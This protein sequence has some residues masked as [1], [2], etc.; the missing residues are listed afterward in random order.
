[1]NILEWL[2]GE[3]QNINYKPKN[4]MVYP[5]TEK[6]KIEHNEFINKLGIKNINSNIQKVELIKSEENLEKYN[7][8]V[9]RKDDILDTEPHNWKDYIG[10]EETK[11]TIKETLEA[12]KQHKNIPYPHILISGNAGIGKSSLIHLLAEKSKLPLIETVAGNLEEKKDVYE[13][14]AKLPKKPP[15]GIIFIDELAGISKIIGEILLP[16]IQTFKVNN[17]PIPYFTFAGATTD[18]GLLNKKLSPLVDRCKQKFRLRPYNN[19][20]L[21]KIIYNQAKKRNIEFTEKALLEIASR[22]RETPRIAL[23]YL[24]NIY[25]FALFRN[26]K[27]IDYL[28]AIE[29]MEKLKIYKLGITNEDIELLKYLSIQEK[30]IGLSTLTQVLNIDELT[31]KNTLEPF[32]VRKKFIGKTSRGRILLEEGRKYL[33]KIKKKVKL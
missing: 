18:L 4:N 23:G 10:Q 9:N 7:F 26:I 13:L 28:T 30:P 8:F 3:E 15:Y 20:E 22:S 31:Y 14:L 11:E 6:E 32:L 5:F 29:K 33:E 27:K 25:Y 21:A 24:D 2:A 12:I 1:M 16:I 19:E 17:K